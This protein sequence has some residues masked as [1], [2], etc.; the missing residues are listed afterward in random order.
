[1]FPEDYTCELCGREVFGGGRLCEECR[2][3]VTFNDGATCPVCGR[4]TQFD[5]M[6]PECKAYSPAYEKAVSAVVYRD[7][8]AKLIMKYKK[9]GAYL[10]EYFADLLIKKCA[11]FSDAEGI[12]YV[13]MTARAERRRGYNQAKLLAEALGERL[14][15]PVLDSALEKLKE[16]AEQKSLDRKEREQNLKGCFRAERA[17]IEGKTLILVDDVMTTGSTAEAAIKQLK[18]RGAKKVYFA[19]AASV[20]YNQTKDEQ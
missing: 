2:A 11:D 3:S 19:T 5:V 16:T 15:L 17:Q 13:P 10:K 4:R 7:G 18:K 1:M 6:C 8:G 9:G 20:Q 12:C 14:N